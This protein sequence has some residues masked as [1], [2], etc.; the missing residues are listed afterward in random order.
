MKKAM[1]AAN[2]DAYVA[3][4]Q[5]WQ[6]DRVIALRQSVREAVPIYEVIKWGH[7]VYFSEGPVVLIRAEERRVLL[8]FWRGQRLR[9]V[10]PRL[11]PGG[12][13]EMATLELQADTE[14][15]SAKVRRLVRE[16]V[17][18]NADIGDPTKAGAGP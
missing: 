9:S 10:E 12:K 4:L 11:R 3:N 2:P 17:R 8:G 16:A 18:L 1:P 5:G 14:I 13:Y 6:R 7:L 15:A